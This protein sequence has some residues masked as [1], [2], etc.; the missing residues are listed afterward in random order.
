MT[1]E[2][3]VSVVIPCFNA[4]KFIGDT[5]KSVDHQNFDSLE[6]I[7]VD[8]G[9]TD[10]SCEVISEWKGIFG[11]RLRTVSG[12]NRG[13]SAARNI[14]T[15]LARGAYIQYLDADDLLRPGTI[16]NRVK[17]LKAGGDIVYCNW[18]KLNENKD[19]TYSS[20]EIINRSIEDIHSDP[21]IA[22]FT[23]FWAPPAAYLYTRE[24][25]N[26]IGGWNE[27]L[28]IVEDARFALEAAFL[29]RR[30]VH[31]NEVG[32]DYRVSQGSS[33]SSRDPMLFV[34][35]CYENACQVEDY[36][37][38][39]GGLSS[40]RCK[41]LASCF[42]YTARTFFVSNYVKFIDNLER[43]N[44]VQPEF[45][46]SFVKVAGVLTKCFGW[47]GARK[48][49]KLLRFSLIAARRLRN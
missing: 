1:L 6:I 10:N 18:Q 5:L 16:E 24:V 32:A 28:P 2:P 11:E 29:G 22:L 14:G 46:L 20:G 38:R 42:D 37:R 33:L 23:R 7:I 8:D 49:M 44:R 9:S 43:L 27:S 30:F 39:N 21:E 48:V 4:A 26:A 40:D 36:W 17:K 45:S 31:L 35:C 3:L 41:A 13:A 25:V 34:K 47:Y 19:G 12:P 15:R